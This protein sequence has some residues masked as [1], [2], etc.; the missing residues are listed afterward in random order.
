MISP[1]LCPRMNLTSQSFVMRKK[2]Y[3]SD[4]GLHTKRQQLETWKWRLAP[5]KSCRQKAEGEVITI[6]V[7]PAP[8]KNGFQSV[9]MVFSLLLCGEEGILFIYHA[10]AFCCIDLGY[11]FFSSSESC[12]GIFQ[13]WLVNSD[14][15]EI[16][17]LRRAFH[18]EIFSFCNKQKKV[19]PKTEKI[20]MWK[21]L[22]KNWAWKIALFD[23]IAIL[24]LARHHVIFKVNLILTF[25]KKSDTNQNTCFEEELV[26]WNKEVTNYLSQL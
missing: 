6:W 9:S 2:D 17:S 16:S 26:I 5:K 24:I 23:N 3:S 8:W 14:L 12:N 13:N 21:L 1:S 10:H 19:S 11:K 20:K 4:D 25:K 15:W 18:V 22:S 7:H